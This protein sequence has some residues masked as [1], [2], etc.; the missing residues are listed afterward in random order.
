MLP[1]EPKPVRPPGSSG[2]P[3]VWLMIPFVAGYF[4]T[5]W[6]VL[7]TVHGL[8]RALDALADAIV[9]AGR[10]VVAGMRAVGHVIAELG[11]RVAAVLRV[12]GHAL[13]DVLRAVGHVLAELGRRVVVVLKAIAHQVAR[14]IR[15][16]GRILAE[17]GRRVAAVLRAAAHATAQLL[18]AVGHVIAEAFRLA[19]RGMVRLLV[20]L[21]P[22]AFTSGRTVGR[23]V[24]RAFVVFLFG[25]LAVRL[26]FHVA[27]VS[28][29]VMFVVTARA[30]VAASR[31]I[32][33]VLGP[34]LRLAA[35]GLAAASRLAAAAVSRVASALAEI[36]SALASVVVRSGRLIAAASYFVVDRLIAPAA[37]SARTMTLVFVGIVIVVPVRAARR[38][39]GAALE[40]IRAPIAAAARALVTSISG[41]TRSLRR[42]MSDARLRLRVALSGAADG[43]RVAIRGARDGVQRLLGRGPTQP[44]PGH[45]RIRP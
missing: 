15:A 28:L 22:V 32:A 3:L 25:L 2:G 38:I 37:R 19:G 31:V 45:R 34:P 7:A 44:G 26:V 24:A 43:I 9:V 39:L 29:R 11:R 27:G 40:S 42:A 4:A 14:P 6:L 16:F 20:V 18:R 36:A 12:V 1:E 23:L 10:G 35:R 13:A 21:R 8:R 33:A 17:L 5:R 30:V 41:A